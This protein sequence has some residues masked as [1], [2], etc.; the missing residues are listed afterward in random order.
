MVENNRTQIFLAGLKRSGTTWLANMINY[1]QSH[2][3]IFEP[4]HPMRGTVSEHV[5]EGQYFSP[6]KQDKSLIKSMKL[7]FSGAL[8]NNWT[9]KN[10]QAQNVEP[11]FIK[12]VRS[13]LL[14]KYLYQHFPNTSFILILRHP[15]AVANSRTK[16]GWR[17]NLRQ[18][19]L[20]PSLI[21]SPGSMV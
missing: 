13:N 2:R 17:P 21:G 18:Y 3:C 12:S 4:F 14:I 5:V 1:D 7:L 10:N 6:D 16:L 11:I 15:C 8:Q 20:Q 19:L 9:D